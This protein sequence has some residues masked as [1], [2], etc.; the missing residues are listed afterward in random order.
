MS[1]DGVIL[2]CAC[3]GALFAAFWMSPRAIQW[4]VAKMLSRVDGIKAQRAAFPKYLASLE[5]E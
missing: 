2:L 3:A 1:F 4:T 5:E